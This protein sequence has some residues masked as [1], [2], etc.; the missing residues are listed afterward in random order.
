MCGAGDVELGG[1]SLSKIWKAGRVLSL[2]AGMEGARG[3][4]H[5]ESFHRCPFWFY[6]KPALIW[7][8]ICH[9]FFL[10]QGLPILLRLATKSWVQVMLPL[11]LLSSYDSGAGLFNLLYSVTTGSTSYCSLLQKL[12]QN[13]RG[14]KGRNLLFKPSKNQCLPYIYILLSSFL[15]FGY[16]FFS[17]VLENY[18]LVLGLIPGSHICFITNTHMTLRKI[19]FD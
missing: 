1:V 12:Y 4:V 2:T 17:H 11:N 16:S 18:S 15:L 7:R 10:R 3:T 13:F 19:T 6:P 5:R 8:L 14:F 9:T